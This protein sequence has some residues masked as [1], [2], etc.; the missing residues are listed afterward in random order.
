MT[1]WIKIHNKILS[2]E[3]LDKPEMISVWLYLLLTAN[4]KDK[5]W[6]GVTVKRGQTIIGR[7]KL[8]KTLGISEQKIR[9]CIKRL[10]S[11]SQITIKTTNRYSIITIVK[12]EEYQGRLEK[13]PDEQPANQQ[14]NNQQ[15]T[16]PKDNKEYKEEE[17]F[18][19]HY[20]EEYKEKIGPQLPIYSK[21][22]ILPKIESYAELFGGY[23]KL[24][25]LL[26]VYLD[27][28]DKFYRTNKWSLTL[29]LTEN[30]LNK[31]ND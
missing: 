18:L 4:W 6:Q 24:R 20:L 1:G 28:E 2:W 25:T 27:K 13:Q 16:T 26:K 19:Y 29:F 7:E 21:R 5:V 9:N 3:W 17:D 22:I 12:W 31:L 23:E 30:V 8:S 14:T 10:K 15:T 11:T